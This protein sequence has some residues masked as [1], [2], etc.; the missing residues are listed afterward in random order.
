[1]KGIEDAALAVTDRVT[2]TMP[3]RI[4]EL[5]TRLS[6]PTLPDLITVAP[7][8]Q[9]TLSMDKWP[10]VL[11]VPG[12]TLTMARTDTDGV[13]EEWTVR[14]RLRA[15]VYVRGHDQAR[16][17]QIRYRLT[18]ALR[19]VLMLS[20]KFDGFSVVESTLRESF[21]DVETPPAGAD[22]IAAAYI[23]FDLDSREELQRGTAVG[24]VASATVDTRVVPHNQPL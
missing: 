8:D 14:Y 5:R 17:A 21:S 3:T 20:R 15:F 4:A 23:E 7:F 12:T 19:E 22:T 13:V 16:T 9:S 18:L 11:V 24:A 1:M 10:A 2:S 6:D